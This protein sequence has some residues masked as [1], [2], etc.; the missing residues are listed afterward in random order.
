M[1]VSVE[2]SYYPLNDTYREQVIAV[3]E[4][5]QNSGLEV[6]ANRMST[7]LFGELDDVMRVL[8]DTM[9]WAFETYG[10]SVF[11]AKIVEGDRRPR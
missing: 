9:R 5:L 3:V 10:R 8:N 7:Q 4:R 1:Y 11:T 6:H 2:L